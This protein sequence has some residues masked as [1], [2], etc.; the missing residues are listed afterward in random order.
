MS[1]VQQG[2][3][4]NKSRA[5]KKF[6]EH[7]FDFESYYQWADHNTT[8]VQQGRIFERLLLNS[9]RSCLYK[10]FVRCGIALVPDGLSFAVR[11]VQEVN[12]N[13]RH[14]YRV[15]LE[16]LT[17]GCTITGKGKW[18]G[19]PVQDDDIQDYLRKKFLFPS[20]I[21]LGILAADGGGV[22]NWRKGTILVSNGWVYDVVIFDAIETFKDGSR[23][24]VKEVRYPEFA[25]RS[26]EERLHFESSKTF[27]GVSFFE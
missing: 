27:D 9:Y 26:M 24:P 10:D 25:F 15:F 1:F 8:S 2:L 5:H 19:N 7:E 21:Y 18:Q 17:Y 23:R 6:V 3:S 4:V 22:E 11:D 16:L 12:V 14:Y 20:S 13:E